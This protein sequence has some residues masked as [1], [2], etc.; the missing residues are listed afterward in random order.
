MNQ[1][2]C[3]K[4]WLYA[5]LKCIKLEPIYYPLY[6]QVLL[7]RK[8]VFLSGAGGTGKS[9]HLNLLAQLITQCIEQSMTQKQK[10]TKSNTTSKFVKL[11]STTGCAAESLNI[12]VINLKNRFPSLFDKYIQARTFHSYVGVMTNWAIEKQKHN[13]D[14]AYLLC[15][16]YKIA[17]TN[18]SQLQ[19]LLLDE[20]SMLGKFYFE[21]FLKYFLDQRRAS[22][23][24]D[25][26]QV[27]FSGDFLQLP[28][29]ND[30]YVFLSS[31]WKSFN[32]S[33]IDLCKN[34]R[35]ANQAWSNFLLKFRFKFPM[36]EDEFKLMD[37][38][39]DRGLSKNG[40]LLRTH[41]T[42][43]EVENTNDSFYN[44]LGQGNEQVYMNKYLEFE[45]AIVYESKECNNVDEDSHKFSWVKNQFSAETLTTLEHKQRE[46]LLRVI[47]D[48]SQFDPLKLKIG[49]VVML[50][51]NLS[52]DGGLVNGSIGTVLA[53][54]E[55]TVDIYFEFAKISYFKEVM[56]TGMVPIGWRP[57]FNSMDQIWFVRIERYIYKEVYTEDKDKPDDYTIARQDV[58]VRKVLELHRFPIRLAYAITVNKSQGMSLDALNIDFDSL[59]PNSYKSDTVKENTWSLLYVALSRVR[60]KDG[61]FLRLS[62]G[63]WKTIQRSCDPPSEALDFEEER[64]KR[65]L[66]LK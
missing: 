15:K 59:N 18:M 53:L 63:L 37:E 30:S 44:Q 47:N 40:A 45:E 35:A 3:T 19:V 34:R 7:E 17:S 42:N 2:L 16:K 41:A 58:C 49:A 26:I 9:F 22:S 11:C 5:Q 61:C 38:L 23:I 21:L 54:N 33:Y 14:Q 50:L 48:A 39:I 8:N 32:F 55:D 12:E 1:P 10:K 31:S 25:Q 57:I 64:F 28:P 24:K 36:K 65:S 13:I 20:V 27:I 52:V 51:K 66:K 4:E 6:E 56:D 62:K 46:T 43:Q 60:S 29:V